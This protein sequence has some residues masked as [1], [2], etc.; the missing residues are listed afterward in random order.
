M[1]K[2][3]NLKFLA[4]AGYEA[5]LKWKYGEEGAGSEGDPQEDESRRENDEG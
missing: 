4:W 3:P 1:N 5:I 2:G